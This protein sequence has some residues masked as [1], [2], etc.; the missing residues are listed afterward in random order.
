MTL[1]HNVLLPEVFFHHIKGGSILDADTISLNPNGPILSAKKGSPFRIIPLHDQDNPTPMSP[2][3]WN[4]S[5]KKE[6]N[7]RL[8]S[9]EW[10]IVAIQNY[11]GKYLSCRR[12]H[13]AGGALAEYRDGIGQFEIF[14]VEYL[15]TSMSFAFQSHNKL[16]L[17]YNHY[18]QII[19]F[20]ERQRENAGWIVNPIKLQDPSNDVI[21]FVGVADIDGHFLMKRT[22][23]NGWNPAWK[24]KDMLKTL[25]ASLSEKMEPES[26]HGGS[27]TIF[28]GGDGQNFW[29][30]TVTK[31]GIF[32]ITIT[33]PEC[34]SFIATW[35]VEK[36]ES[37]FDTHEEMDRE[38]FLNELFIDLSKFEKTTSTGA[39][40][41]KMKEYEDC[42]WKHIIKLQDNTEHALDLVAHTEALQNLGQECFEFLSKLPGDKWSRGVKKTPD[43][44][45]KTVVKIAGGFA[46]SKL[47]DKLLGKKATHV[48]TDVASNSEME[49]NGPIFK[50][51]SRR[52]I[53]VDNKINAVR[54]NA[55]SGI[56]SCHQIEGVPHLPL[57]MPPPPPTP[58]N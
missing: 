55:S 1:Q 44:L 31:V 45:I 24:S 23:I 54:Q 33:S 14:H 40:H 28:E 29:Y 19:A 6:Y 56:Q 32:N 25:L 48:V 46:A 26:C 52:F 35:C 22:C 10:K 47:G 27:C 18:A 30:V 36:V 12:K 43:H 51:F 38:I 42:M 7:E 37:I 17:H 3:Y 34:P 8:M 21:R 53:S 49:K 50:F 11:E 9:E 2:S 20:K 5:S 58:N 41:N 4:I 16:Y 13:P 57:S 15:P 39:L